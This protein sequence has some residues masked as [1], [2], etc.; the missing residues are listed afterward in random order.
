MLCD[1]CDD[2]AINIAIN[3]QCTYFLVHHGTLVFFLYGVLLLTLHQFFRVCRVV[4]REFVFHSGSEK[5][6]SQILTHV[7]FSS[8]ANLFFFLV[9]A[10][11]IFVFYSSFVCCRKSSKHGLCILVALYYHSLFIA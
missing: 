10:H 11:S 1:C 6:L 7:Y 5:I 2:I 3:V 8:C 4:G 9:Q